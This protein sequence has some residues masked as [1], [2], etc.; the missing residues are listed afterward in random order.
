[1][2]MDLITEFQR[3]IGKSV[4]VIVDFNIPLLIINRTDQWKT[5]KDAEDLYTATNLT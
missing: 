3:E 5:S 2:F 4:T 1:M